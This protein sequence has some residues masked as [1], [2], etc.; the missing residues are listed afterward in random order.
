MDCGDVTMMWALHGIP[1]VLQVALPLALLGWQAFHPEP[2]ICRWL[3]NTGVV[4]LYLSAVAVAGLWLLV[5]WYTGIGFILTAAALG[6]WQVPTVRRLP[7]RGERPS[8]A[9]IGA[10][11][12]VAATAILALAVAAAGR[13]LPPGDVVDLEFPL[14]DGTYYV[15]GGG[16]TELVNPHVM[17]LASDRFRAYR[18]QSYGVDLVKLG[19]L[20]SRATGFLPAEPVRYAVYGDAVYAPCSGVTV[21]AKDGFPD[22]PPPEPDRSQMAGNHVLLECSGVHVLLAH[23]QRGSVR[24]RVHQQVR[25]GTLIGV[26]GNSGN[27]NE[28]HL[29]IH[30][31][32]P[33]TNAAE[34]L[35]GEPL[36]VRFNGR[37]LVRN[38]RVR[39][40][41]RSAIRGEAGSGYARGSRQP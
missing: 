12:A 18:G 4:I 31:Q 9:S 2:S 27:S 10:R 5:P 15:T 30:A 29:H 19:A 22:M 3:I 32:R 17:T 24:L 35:S 16:S 37:F 39:S 21:D 20:G 14:R 8:W 13:Q 1:L 33:A 36:P 6:L 34:R 38:D 23:L 25:V 7:W 26:V 11:M 41:V 40:V 28:P